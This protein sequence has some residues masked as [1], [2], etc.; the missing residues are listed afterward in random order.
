MEF[1]HRRSLT[2][3]FHLVFT[4]VLLITSD[5]GVFN[6]KF[7]PFIVNCLANI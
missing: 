1:G 5:L 4:N 6:R 7:T 3:Y 2:L